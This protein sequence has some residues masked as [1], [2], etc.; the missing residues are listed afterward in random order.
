MT[1][2][3]WGNR[4]EHPTSV[5]GPWITFLLKIGRTVRWASVEE[6]LDA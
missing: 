4:R 6:V 5:I 1:S 3:R 2:V